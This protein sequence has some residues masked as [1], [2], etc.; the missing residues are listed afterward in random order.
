MSERIVDFIRDGQLTK[1]VIIT[2]P[3][4]LGVKLT[5]RVIGELEGNQLKV[6]NIVINHVVKN[7]DCAFHTSRKKMQ[8]HYIDLI[9]NTYRDI[10]V[11]ILYLS[12]EEVKGMERIADVAEALFE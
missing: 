3:E 9:K 5:E 12:A 10:N 2:I 4:A 7:A 11:V 1:Y 6:E 8:N